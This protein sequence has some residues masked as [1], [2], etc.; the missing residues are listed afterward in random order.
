MYCQAVCTWK[1]WNLPLSWFVNERMRLRHCPHVSVWKRNFFSLFSKKF[2]ST[3]SF[4][5]SFSPVH[6]YTMNR[7]E[8]YDL[9]NCSCL[10]LSCSLLWAREI[11]NW[12]HLW[13]SFG[14]IREGVGGGEG[15]E[16]ITLLFFT[17]VSWPTPPASMRS[18]STGQEPR[19]ACVN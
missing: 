11:I 18:H 12:R 7:F 15:R 16:K 8:N 2:A 3:R 1:L 14:W 13:N 5:A 19:V 9:P 4:F 17:E 6:T 10:T